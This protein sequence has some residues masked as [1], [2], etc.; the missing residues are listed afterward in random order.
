MI[1]IKPFNHDQNEA[2]LIQLLS[3]HQEELKQV[4]AEK[5]QTFS[6]AI[7]DN[8]SYIG[9]ITANKWMNATHISLLALKNQYH[10]CGYGSQLLKQAEEFA[11]EAGSELITVHTQEYQAKR[12]YEKF[13]YHVF[14]K[15][16]DTPFKG[17]TKYYLVKR[18]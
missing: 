4:P 3:K 5:N 14:G 1:T 6:L 13:G 11:I 8:Q 12:F 17:T 16:V 9:G 7:Y 2:N 18:I 10:G 15:L